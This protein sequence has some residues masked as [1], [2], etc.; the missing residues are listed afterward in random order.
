MRENAE[1][2]EEERDTRRAR[3]ENEA[4]Y[5]PLQPSDQDAPE[6]RVLFSKLINLSA[7]WSRTES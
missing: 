7:T 2:D 3:K 6:L 1:K 5:C 4:A